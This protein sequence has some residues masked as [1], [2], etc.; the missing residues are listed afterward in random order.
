MESLSNGCGNGSEPCSD[1]ATPMM[2]RRRFL[3]GTSAALAWVVLPDGSKAQAQ[4]ARF[5]R[6]QVG[7]VSQLKPN[8]PSEFQYPLK[9][10]NAVNTLIRLNE[11]AGGGVGPD[12]SIVAFNNLCTHLGASMSTT[13]DGKAG[14]AGPC[15][16]H[17]TTFDLSRHGM[18]ISG[19][20]TLS[21]TQILLE[22]DGDSIFAVGVQGLIYGTHD[23]FAGEKQ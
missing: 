1:L 2:D 3:L 20:A 7:Q 6:M 13:F 17:W 10:E 21:L 9:H 14:I 12:N 5:D 18:V 16:L 19:H 8:A 11:P 15:P 4:V 22:V 23:N